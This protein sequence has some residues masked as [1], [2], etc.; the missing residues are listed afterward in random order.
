MRVEGYGSCPAMTAGWHCVDRDTY[1][2]GAG[3]E[4][5]PDAKE[6]RI[7]IR[8]RAVAVRKQV[9]PPLV[10]GET[11]RRSKVRTMPNGVTYV[12]DA[13]L[14]QI[15]PLY[16]VNLDI[17]ALQMVITETCNAIRGTMV[18]DLFLMLPSG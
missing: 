17:S 18:T 9:A 6:L 7:Q 8:D 2:Y 5:L 4:A 11:R 3:A 1:G 16:N 10:A 15:I 12:P 14:Q 13:Q